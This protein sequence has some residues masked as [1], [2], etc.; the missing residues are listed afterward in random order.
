MEEKGI[1]KQAWRAGD[2][3]ELREGTRVDVL[4]PPRRQFSE[5]QEDQGLVLRFSKR[6][7]ALLYAGD[8]SSAVEE[9]L[10]ASGVELQA[11]I[12]IQGE[13]SR[14][15]NLGGPWL[16]A[17]RPHWLV[18]P[19]R[20]FHPDRGMGWEKMEEL[21]QSGVDLFRMEQSGALQFRIGQDGDCDLRSWFPEEKSFK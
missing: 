4:W 1:P 3:F 21:R 18:R 10:V 14:E 20:G 9:Q 12:L 8:I 19:E 11:E 15:A 7:K 5:R 16:K 2:S 13:H 17:V 6:G